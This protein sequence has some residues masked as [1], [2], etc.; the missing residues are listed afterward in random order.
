MDKDSYPSSSQKRTLLL[1]ELLQCIVRQ[2]KDRH[3]MVG[4][5]KVDRVKRCFQMM[6]H[7]PCTVWI[8][9]LTV[10]IP[11]SY[12]EG[13]QCHLESLG[14]EGILQP[15]DVILGAV[16]PVRIT[17]VYQYPSFTERP[18]TT[19]CTIPPPMSIRPLPPA[20]YWY[21]L[22]LTLAAITGEQTCSF[23][24]EGQ[25]FHFGYF[26]QLQAFL[27]AVE[28]INKEGRLLPNVTLGV[29]WYDSCG[30]TPVNTEGTL[31]VLSGHGTAIPNYRCLRNVPLSAFIGSASSTHSIS[32][33][34]ILGLYRY[35]QVSHYSTSSFLSHKL[36]FPS[37]FR[38]VPSDAFQSVGLAK[39][40]LHFRWSWIGLLAVDNDYG[41][42]GI[43]VVRQEIIKAGACVAF[44]EN[45]LTSKQDRNA[46]HIVKVIKESSARTVVVFST[47]L[48]LLPILNE[49]V[50]QN[51]KGILFVAS[52]GWSTTTLQH[53]ERFSHLLF[54]TVGLAYYSGLIP[55]FGE[56]LNKIHPNMT[57]GGNLVKSFWEEAF[58][59]KF[60]TEK[61]LSIQDKVC[62][63]EENLASIRNSYNDVSNLRVSYN[64]Y[65]AVYVVANALKDLREGNKGEGPVSH[66]WNFS[67]W[68]L[69]HY[70][71]RVRVKL[72]S[73]RE[74][75]FDENGDPPALYDIVNWQLG[76][77]DAI[78]QV[79]VGSYDTAASL[80]QVFTINS[81]LLLWATE[82]KQVP[83]SVCTESCPPGFRKA[84]R[85][86]QPT[87]CFQCVPCPQGEISNLTDSIDCV[88][89]P[90]N[91][92]PN[93]EKSKCLEKHMEFLSYD[94]PLGATL[95]ITSILSFFIPN[96]ILR[97][98]RQNKSTPI[99]KANN[100]SLS[101]LL[102]VSLSLCFLCPLAF[103]GYPQPEKCL[104]RQATFGLVFALCISCIL[105]KTIMVVFAFMATRPGSNLR[106]WTN[107]RVSYMIIFVG[108]LLQFLLC[109]TWLS[110]AP[111]FPQYNT[112][113]LPT[114][115]IAECNEGSTISFW[116]MLAY[117]FLLATISFIVAFLARRLPDSFNEAQYIT[118]SMLAFLSVWVSFIPAS[119]SAQGKY[120]VAME[121][122]AILA[123]SWALVICM[124]LP[125][126]FILVFRPDMNSKEHLMRRDR[127]Q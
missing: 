101:C 19:T 13:H 90:W 116:T 83:V 78:R 33:A 113:S 75:Y 22:R 64:I 102:L 120:T 56:F 34:N 37:F 76:P 114:I 121:I 4:S 124:F 127:D 44:M 97:L 55:G 14:L 79:K 71:K 51:I 45:I 63:G 110:I 60:P 30:V 122:F 27:F 29:Q 42:Q 9:L 98:F 48:D 6:S 47:G 11:F 31:Q 28:E 38:T 72:S 5:V 109:I 91:E 16:L 40:V 2:L 59:C 10:I 126:C 1:L 125:K 119:L 118:F 61:N 69:L 8:F 36:Q 24:F 105:A 23:Q 99:V 96:L 50:K 87:C 62:T 112:Q 25:G 41:Q 68:Q 7:L 35:P 66:I 3:H 88:T 84:A 67:P 32:V 15:G 85:R 46:P 18:P 82:D 53:M 20:H 86:G 74:L 58:N 39:L 26:Q 65:T 57:L 100:Y 49:I 123:S 95:T 104:L 52:E 108:F 89:C 106:R 12:N 107:P 54:G 92:W 73:R 117:L 103:I 17:N 21:S 81:S 115:I 93:P 111:P 80:G 77:S 94:D 70:M 43:Q